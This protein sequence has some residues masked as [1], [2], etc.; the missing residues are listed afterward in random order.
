M[1]SD[2]GDHKSKIFSIRDTE[3]ETRIVDR[4]RLTCPKVSVCRSGIR[5]AGL[6]VYSNCLIKSG[7][8]FGPYEGAFRTN[9]DLSPESRDGD[10]A[11]DVGDG[12]Y[13]DA[14]NEK[15]SNWMRYV[16][17]GDA[18]SRT[19]LRAVRIKKEIFY[20]VWKDIKPGFEL[21]IW[22]GVDYAD[23]L[24]CFDDGE[25]GDPEEL[26]D[27]YK[28]FKCNMLYS[29]REFLCKHFRRC[30]GKIIVDEEDLREPI[31]IWQWCS[32]PKHTRLLMEN[33]TCYN[34][35]ISRKEH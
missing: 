8:M 35:L 16:N 22:Y 10:Y 25:E 33:V 7:T 18:H 26:C 29:C 21:L 3:V 12:L 9:V 27:A 34:C 15:K 14:R 2:C 24:G 11:W 17:N 1:D 6:G 19:N 4:A 32:C 28:C 23:L 31:L 30:R 13:V 5:D 20:V